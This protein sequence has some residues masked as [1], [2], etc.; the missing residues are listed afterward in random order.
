VGGWLAGWLVGGWLVDGED[1][2]TPPSKTELHSAP[3]RT[4]ITVV[5]KARNE[6]ITHHAKI[7]TDLE[8]NFSTAQNSH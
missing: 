2:E 4:V 7:L 5:E 6:N 1:R 3:H 8:F